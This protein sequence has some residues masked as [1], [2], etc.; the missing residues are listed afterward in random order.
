M[1]EK[2]QIIVKQIKFMLHTAL[3]V[4]SILLHGCK[5]DSST[6]T[7]SMSDKDREQFATM[8]AEKVIELQRQEQSEDIDVSKKTCPINDEEG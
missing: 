8:V 1:S 3:L 4:M 7:Y 6:T 5:V 2:T